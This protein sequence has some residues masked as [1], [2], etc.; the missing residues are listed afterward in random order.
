MFEDFARTDD[1]KFS[2]DMM[3]EKKLKES[4]FIFNTVDKYFDNPWESDNYNC[5]NLNPEFIMKNFDKNWDYQRLT[6]IVSLFFILDNPGRDWNYSMLPEKIDDVKNF[7]MLE[8]YIDKIIVILDN[9]ISIDLKNGI[10]KSLSKNVEL[11]FIKQHVLLLPW[12]KT[13]LSGRLT[14]YYD[15]L[16]YFIKTNKSLLDFSLLSQKGVSFDIV[17]QNPNES[18]DFTELSK[19][20]LIEVVFKNLGFEWDFTELSKRVTFKE[21]SS[22][23]E[24]NWD[25]NILYTSFIPNKDLNDSLEDFIN[26]QFQVKERRVFSGPRAILEPQESVSSVS[27]KD[28]KKFITDCF[29]KF[30]IYNLPNYKFFSLDFIKTNLESKWNFKTMSSHP[31]ITLDFVRDLLSKDWDWESIYTN[32]N[33]QR[34]ITREY[35]S[36]L[37]TLNEEKQQNSIRNLFS[38]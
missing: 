19:S 36:K 33:I 25:F 6:S 17:L 21:F 5:F 31:D 7:Q 11:S 8:D 35:F 10:C 26:C 13:I 3:E 27:K 1:D 30:D 38:F 4:I 16:R 29:S 22:K 23:P 34:D 14:E 18:W 2:K 37:K 9:S 32:S 20:T 12:D 24:L 15:D 28:Y